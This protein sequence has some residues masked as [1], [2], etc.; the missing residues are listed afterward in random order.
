[1][2]FQKQLSQHLKDVYNG[3]NWTAVNLSTT[4]HDVDW[5]EAIFKIDHLNTIAVLVFHINYYVEAVLNVLDG[6]P[7]QASDLYSFDL[8]EI[9][10]EE[11]WLQLKEKLFMNGDMLASKIETLNETKLFEDFADPKYGNYCRNLMGIVEHIHYHLGQM[12]LIKKIMRQQKE[13]TTA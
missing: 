3:N 10:A 12:V 5:Q 7:L 2:T 1:M 4:L 11:G 6:N 9:N 13:N 8:Q